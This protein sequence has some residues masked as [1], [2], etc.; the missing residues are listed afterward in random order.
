M[1]AKEI[2]RRAGRVFE[3]CLPD[4]WAF[5][6]QEDQEDYGID[7]EIEIT[8]PQ[9]K[10]TG[11]IFKAQI[12]G[13]KAVSFI[14]ENSK[15]SFSISLERLQYYLANVE[16]AVI[17]FVVDITNEIVYWHSLQDDESLR[18]R[19]QDA[20]VKDQNTITVHLQTKN[21]LKRDNINELI[22]AI[23]INLDWLR[24]NGLRKINYSEIFKKST[25]EKVKD[26]L[27]QAKD[28]SYYAYMEQFERLYLNKEHK[29]LL[30]LIHQVFPSKTEKNELRFY[31]GLYAEKIC[32]QDLGFGS[33]DYFR[34]SFEIFQQVLDL[35]RIGKFAK[36]YH[37]YIILLWRSWLL[38]QQINIDYHHF[39]SVKIVG[40]DPFVGMIAQSV[41]RQSSLRV[42]NSLLKTIRLVNHSIDQKDPNIFL[43]TFP[44]LATSIILLV[45]KLRDESQK[46]AVEVLEDWLGY[47][48]D[49]GLKL[50]SNSGQE[51]LFILF[52]NVFVSLKVFSKDQIGYIAVARQM[53]EWLQRKDLQVYFLEYLDKLEEK[54]INDNEEYNLS[55]DEELD[56]YKK[57]AKKLGFD[58]D[59]PNNEFG[60]IIKQGLEDYNPERVLK[61]CEHLLVFNSS[62]L[63]MPARIVGLP[64]ATMK[65]I[66]CVE[67]KHTGGGWSL[68][69]AYQG[70]S[71]IPDSGF[72]TRHCINCDK[73]KSRVDEWKW[74]SK[75]QA[76]MYT[77]NMELYKKLDSR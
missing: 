51:E 21:V 10:A 53:L 7:G 45:H 39:I 20:L 38:R 26:W 46:E 17:L 3:F 67:Y 69:I 63:G 77:E 71:G 13:Q 66:H 68:D 33:E 31:A 34:V 16:I 35:V 28:Q 76:E 52:L 24:L 30:E 43:D 70:I 47:C 58:F 44:K 57:H 62:A 61:E 32:E 19:M 4:N 74:D 72:K 75:W 12:K 8:T 11:F 48:I 25:D 55:P 36:Y 5:R 49:L 37:I 40:N 23:N 64:S 22:Q 73:C 9:D 29:K 65:I 54:I 18:E 1:N 60:Q 50:A 59:D 15:V 41:Q 27:E 56:F 42:S 14:E 2:G 6:S